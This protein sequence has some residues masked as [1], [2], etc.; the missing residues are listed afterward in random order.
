MV[1]LAE[2]GATTYGS[3]SSNRVLT[4]LHAEFQTLLWAMKSSIQLDHLVMTFETDCLQLVHLIE[5]D[6]EDNW[7]S[8]LHY[9]KTQ[10]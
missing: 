9:K 7:L 2:D 5:E 3:F 4:P 8:L 1:L 6:E 10:I